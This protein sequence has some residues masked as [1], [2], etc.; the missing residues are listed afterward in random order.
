MRRNAI[1]GI[2][3]AAVL[4]AVLGSCDSGPKGGELTVELVTPEAQLGAVSFKVTATSPASIDSIVPAC[5]GC[6]VYTSRVSDRDV[7]G[8]VTGRFGPGP[9]IAV[10]VPDRG[11]RD[12]Y[13]FQLLEFAAADY[14]LRSISG[15][16]LRIVSN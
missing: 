14:T 11:L 6:A 4:L 16:S 1:V 5:Q 3:A 15:S 10:V 8:I 12:A 13:A 7:R 2:L 9:V